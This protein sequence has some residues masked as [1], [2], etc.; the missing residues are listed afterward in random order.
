[1]KVS[2][3]SCHILL[4]LE[5]SRQIMANHQ[6]STFLKLRPLGAEV[7]NADRRTDKHR[8]TPKIVVAIHHFATAPI[9]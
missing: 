5:I 7:L 9:M 4:N 6:I 8:V 3:Y 2:H 1:M